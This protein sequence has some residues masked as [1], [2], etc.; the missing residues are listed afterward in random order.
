MEV[1]VPPATTLESPK[2]PKG[3]KDKDKDNNDKDREINHKEWKETHLKD[4]YL[5]T[6]LIGSSL[7]NKKVMMLA[8]KLTIHSEKYLSKNSMLTRMMRSTT[9]K[10]SR[11]QRDKDKIGSFRR[12]KKKIG[13][14][15]NQLPKKT[16]PTP[17][18]ILAIVMQIIAESIM[19]RIDS[20]KSPGLKTQ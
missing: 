2:I 19:V 17:T 5:P 3:S 13:P 1:G 20:I 8:Q 10:K 12:D 7:P 11:E 4:N 15:R 16:I 18:K 9:T 6:K 14:K